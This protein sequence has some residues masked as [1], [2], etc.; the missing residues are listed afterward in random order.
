MCWQFCWIICSN[1]RVICSCVRGFRPRLHEQ[2]KQPLFA[3]IRPEYLHMDREFE[4]LKEVLFAHVN[5]ALVPAAAHE[6]RERVRLGRVK[7]ANKTCFNC[8]NSQSVWS[9]PGQ[10]CSNKG[11]FICSCKRGL[12]VTRW[13]RLKFLD[14]YM[15][16]SQPH[17][18]PHPPSIRPV[19]KKE[20]PTPANSHPKTGW[21][22][23]KSGWSAIYLLHWGPT[24]PFAIWGE[25]SGA[26]LKS[27][28]MGA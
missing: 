4:Q 25:G 20:S 13:S 28:R 22:A 3:Q 15:S 24:D 18:S 19:N 6:L 11:C 16:P 7:W 10:I 1:C 12:T 27:Q 26:P 5:A 8:S 23:K 9:K 14:E 17:H 2:I 21:F